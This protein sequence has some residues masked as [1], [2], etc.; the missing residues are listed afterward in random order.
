MT[1]HQSTSRTTSRA[2]R[3][4]CILFAAFG[5]AQAATAQDQV[6]ILGFANYTYEYD[7]TTVTPAGSQPPTPKT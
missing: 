4:L 2:F 1:V 3:N 7:D 6:K 5:G